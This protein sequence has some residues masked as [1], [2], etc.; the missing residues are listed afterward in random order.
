M[1]PPI[2]ATALVP[3]SF[4]LPMLV[5]SVVPINEHPSTVM[6][7][8]LLVLTPALPFAKVQLI[9]LI[10]VTPDKSIPRPFIKFACFILKLMFW[11]TVPS[12]LALLLLAINPLSQSIV[13]LFPSIIKV[14]GIV[15]ALNTS[16]L[17]QL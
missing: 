14:C 16:E 9:I 17:C 7:E 6:S 15:I 4:L 2:I 12:T 1:D 3:F 5:T 10:L 11:K 13:A 8:Q